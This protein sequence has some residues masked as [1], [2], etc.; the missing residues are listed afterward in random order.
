MIGTNKSL[1]LVLTNKDRGLSKWATE[2]KDKMRGKRRTSGSAEKVQK[3]KPRFWRGFAAIL[4]PLGNNID[5]LA[6]RTGL[7][8]ATSCVTGRH[9]NQLNYHS[10]KLTQT[11]LKI[12]YE[13]LHLLI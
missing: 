10:I 3:Q 8:P 12:T 13:F 11:L 7:E 6:E 4:P 1:C 9:S 5:L 2:N